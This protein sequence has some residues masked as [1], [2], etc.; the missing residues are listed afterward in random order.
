QQQQEAGD[1]TQQQQQQEVVLF[2]EDLEL[3][4]AEQEAFGWWVFD[5]AMEEDVARRHAA[6]EQ[7]T[8]DKGHAAAVIQDLFEVAVDEVEPMPECKI[9]VLDA[10]KELGPIMGAPECNLDDPVAG[11]GIDGAERLAARDFQYSNE[12]WIAAALRNSSHSAPDLA[13]ADFVFVD[14]HCYHVAWMSYNHPLGVKAGNA[15]PA[16]WVWRTTELMLDLPLFRDTKG[17]AFAM[18]FPSPALSG[19][20]PE[21]DACEELSSVFQLV[22]EPG[23]LCAWTRDSHQRN[24]SMV[25]P[26]LASSDL[27]L[28]LAAHTPAGG[29]SQLQSV[30]L[31]EAG[32]FVRA[33]AALEGVAEGSPAANTSALL[34]L[35]QAL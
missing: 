1:Q 18:A 17:G 11:R 15:D 35:Q 29:L 5:Q 34:A 12:H 14:M 24:R 28:E 3:G 22:P 6:I 8:S 30:P 4:S 2:S 21:D 23:N 32:R 10:A 33:G 7:A 9:Y 26:Y 20:F 31:A 16:P 25:L 13:S 19:F 27:E